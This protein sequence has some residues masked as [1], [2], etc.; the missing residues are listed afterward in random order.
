MYAIPYNAYE[1]HMMINVQIYRHRYDGIR[2][3]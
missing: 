3:A 1:M 2:I